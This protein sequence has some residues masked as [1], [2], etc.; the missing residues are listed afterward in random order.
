MLD[1]D[2]GAG[3][4]AQPTRL[5]AGAPLGPLAH[6]AVVYLLDGFVFLLPI[7]EGQLLEQPFAL[8]VL[9]FFHLLL[10]VVGSVVRVQLNDESL[11]AI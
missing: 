1:H 11:L 5:T 8:F 10:D 6:L 4:F 2:P 9:E 7:E 3:A